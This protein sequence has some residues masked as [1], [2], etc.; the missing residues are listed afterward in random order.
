MGRMGWGKGA[1]GGTV[2]R[3]CEWERDLAPFYAFHL[4][5]AQDALPRSNLAAICDV[6]LC[7]EGGAL[8]AKYIPYYHLRM[9][10]PVIYCEQCS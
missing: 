3:G 10:K 9:Q 1:A 4:C 2:W 6:Q 7:S 8:H 5:S